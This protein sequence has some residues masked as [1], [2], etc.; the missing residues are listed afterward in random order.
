MKQA[1]GEQKDFERKTIKLIENINVVIEEYARQGLTLSVRQIYYQLVARGFIPNKATEYKKISR[2]ITDGR[3]AGLIDWDCIEDRTRAV[4]EIQHWD[5]P[6]QILRAAAEQYRIDTRATQP[7]Y[8]EAWIE[9]DSLVSI[10]QNTCYQLDVPVFSCKGY[11]S[12]TALHEAAERFEGKSNPIILYAGDHDPTGLTIPQVINERFQLFEMNVKLK[13][14][15]LTLDQI[16]ELDLPP[17]PA[18]DTDGNYKK[19]VQ[20]TGLTHA[21]EL[22]ALPP[23]KLSEIFEEAINS[24]TDFEALRDMQ[25]RQNR[26]KSYFS[27]LLNG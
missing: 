16:K 13:R 26:D 22:D 1:Y 15:G 5:N 3:L 21:W 12:I 11:S 4:R 24:L 27:E 14:I 9:K 23:E 25:E 6:Q 10:L 19:Y 7:S 8:I 20:D 2:T 17:F 18:K